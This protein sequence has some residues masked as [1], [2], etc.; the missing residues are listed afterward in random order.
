MYPPHLS[1]EFSGALRTFAYWMASGTVGH[2]LLEGAPDY[3]AVMLEEPSLMEMAF[4]IYANVL[5]LSPEGVPRNA[6]YAE[7]RA[8]QYIRQYVEPDYVVEPPFA[9]WETSL[10]SPPFGPEGAADER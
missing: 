10:Y 8:A 3:R 7:R 4:A 2:P 6:R 5:T 9:D 1:P